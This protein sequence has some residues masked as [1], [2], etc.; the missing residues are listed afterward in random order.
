MGTVPSKKTRGRAKK[1]IAPSEPTSSKVKPVA[2]VQTTYRNPTKEN[3]VLTEE[4]IEAL[5]YLS[6]DSDQEKEDPKV[7][8]APKVKGPVTRK[9]NMPIVAETV[10]AK[11]SK[12]VPIYMRSAE[13]PKISAN[14]RIETLDPFE[15]SVDSDEE[16]AKKKKKKRTKRK[17]KKKEAGIILPF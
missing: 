16:E 4:E 9:K 6:D 13:E 1:D 14:P 11:E 7:K 15:M 12:K 10:Q 17:P 3:K 2:K 5:A 8:E